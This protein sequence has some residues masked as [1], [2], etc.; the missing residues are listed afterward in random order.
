[1]P[2]HL[3]SISAAAILATLCINIFINY[4][5]GNILPSF[6]P[7]FHRSPEVRKLLILIVELEMII[8]LGRL[9]QYRISSSLQ[10]LPRMGIKQ[11]RF[12]AGFSLILFLVFNF[13]SFYLVWRIPLVFDGWVLFEMLVISMGIV[14]MYGIGAPFAA[15]RFWR[16]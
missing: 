14:T 2:L 5:L 3:L 10:G 6:I 11:F 16:A 1:M 9:R 15:R 12:V 4:F 13:H 8:L 7:W